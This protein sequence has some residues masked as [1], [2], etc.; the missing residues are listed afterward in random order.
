[1]K[2]KLF[3]LAAAIFFLL[4]I[5]SCTNQDPA[6]IRSELLHADRDFSRLSEE[7]GMMAAFLEFADSSAV[8]LRPNRYPVEG[9]HAVREL[10]SASHGGGFTLTWEPLQA[11]AASSGDMGYTYGI[12]SVRY[13]LPDG[14]P[15]EDR[16]TYVTI[17][18]RDPSGKWKYVLDTGNEGLITPY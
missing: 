17:W 1:M 10:L 11:H 18:K 5:M 6:A 15:A 7:M 9:I 13:S 12:Y 3:P 4:M 16:G 8:L 14:A 2:R